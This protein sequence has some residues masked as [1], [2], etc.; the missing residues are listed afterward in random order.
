MVGKS[1]I[2][3]ITGGASRVGSAIARD[4]AKHGWSLVLHVNRSL[5]NAAIL[6]KEVQALG[7]EARVIAA[8]LT[9]S[10]QLIPYLDRASACFGVP[11]VIINNA[12]IFQDDGIGHLD[13]VVFDAHHHIHTRAPV[14]LADAFARSLEKD[15]KGLVVNIIDQ[16]V[17]KLTPQAMS[18][19][20]SKAGLW[21]ATQTLAQALAPRIRVNAIGPGPSFK[22]ERQSS[23]EFA[24]QAKAVP[25]GHGPQVG[26]FGRTIRFLWQSP[27]ITGQMIALD[28]GQH[29]AWETPDVIGVG[30]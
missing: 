25:L 27:S 16:R 19:T 14:F 2:A 29:L 12:S 8:D 4:L 20:L 18:Y 28:G 23:A 15:R 24:K 22:N 26:E 9:D 11:D 17:W 21:A 3:V 5:E 7:G 13:P 1:A 6:A 30:E 10:T